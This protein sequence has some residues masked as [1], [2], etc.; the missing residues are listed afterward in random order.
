MSTFTLSLTSATESE[1]VERVA[2][3]AGEDASGSFGILPGHA[4]M[5]TILTFGMVR[6]RPVDG[7]WEYL[8]VPGGVLY[9]RGDELRLVTRRYLRGADYGN[10]HA[11]LMRE[12]AAEEESLQAMRR[13]VRRLEEEM[14]KR[15][16]EA[17]RGTPP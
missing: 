13:A 11:A 14:L 12:F 6:F 9:M 17:S 1:R 16:V 4:R 8:A 15:L 2:S 7:P 5:I 3:F 10:L